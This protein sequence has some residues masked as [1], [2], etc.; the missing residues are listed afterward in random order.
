MDFIFQKV[1]VYREKY[2]VLAKFYPINDKN[3]G[4]A[5]LFA[6]IVDKNDLD[7]SIDA[8]I[9]MIN[10]GSCRKKQKDPTPLGNSKY[11]EMN[12]VEAVSDPAQKCVMA[13]MDEC[14][15]KKVRILN[16]LDYKEGNYEKA[17]SVMEN[18]GEKASLFSAERTE[19]RNELMQEDAVIIA[20][21]GT[22]KRLAKLKIQACNCLKDKKIIGVRPDP[23]KEYY[24]YEYIKPPTQA[25]QIKRIMQLVECFQQYQASMQ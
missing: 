13:F 17:M 18:L 25:A 6:D 5:R 9:I 12:L 23:E 3:K 10:P 8:Y 11:A 14:K 22:D 24:D 4:D 1:N 2:A 20:A 15:L 7:A 19:I 21:W 16:L